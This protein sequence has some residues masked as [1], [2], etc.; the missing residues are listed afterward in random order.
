MAAR[1]PE[2]FWFL[3]LLI[4]LAALAFWRYRGGSKSVRVL[5]G[6]WR[7]KSFSDIFLVRWFFSFL[8]LGLFIVFITL[9]LAG[10]PGRTK[11]E[12]YGASGWDTV[13]LL[14]ISRS[15]YARDVSPSRLDKAKSTIQGI[16]D[17]LDTGRFGL[18]VFRGMGSRLFP[19][20]EDKT[21][22]TNF[23]GL[24]SPD[25][26][27]AP[28]TDLPGGLEVALDS[29][30][31]GMETNRRVI[32][33]S[34]GGEFTGELNSI[35]NKY[36]DRGVSLVVIGIG[37]AEG[38]PIVLP[39]GTTVR[40][41]SGREVTSRLNARGLARLAESAGGKYYSGDDPRLL[42]HIN[43]D[44]RMPT[45]E[46]GGGFIEVETEGFRLYLILALAGLGVF[47]GARTGKWKE[48]L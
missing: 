48:T 29:F 26:M 44:Y 30:V 24:I 8:G 38:S 6:A 1:Y 20:S 23:L 11:R 31:S 22:L 16:A 13:F 32:L 46:E 9:S 27:T 12:P 18:V 37:T 35:I 42:T 5:G 14:D 15:M 45:L 39:D 7:K 25:L 41:A 34:D 10:F 4:P 2:V 33:L 36:R 17:S 19:L 28:G 40:D 43:E 21:G 47:L 3:L